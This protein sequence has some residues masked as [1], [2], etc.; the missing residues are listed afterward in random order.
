[1]NSFFDR[2][3]V[4]NLDRDLSRRENIL[5]QFAKH[6]ITNYTIFSATDK[7]QVSLADMA[8]E[9]KWAYPGNTFYCEPTCSCSGSGHEL[10]EGQM[11]CHL[12]HYRVWCDIIQNNYSKCLVLE[13]DLMLVDDANQIFDELLPQIP[14]DWNFIQLGHAEMIYSGG[15]RGFI[16]IKSAFAQTHCYAITHG[17]AEIFKKH[18]FPIR[19]A[20]DGYIAHFMSPLIKGIYVSTLNLGYNGSLNNNFKSQI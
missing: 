14:Q 13:D 6:H 4:I 3:Y 7:L 18:T 11:A 16:P 9:L 17:C 8:K 15:V 1:M 12:S 10:S 2:I 19:A 5:K 20:V